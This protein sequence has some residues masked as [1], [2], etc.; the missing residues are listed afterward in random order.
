MDSRFKKLISNI[1]IFFVGTLG[2]R[3]IQ[4]IFVPFYTYWLSTEEYGIIDTIVVTNLL[5]GPLVGLSIHEALLRFLLGDK[6]D[7]KSYY[8]VSIVCWSVCAVLFLGG[9]FGFCKIDFLSQYWWLF[10]SHV[11]IN[12]LW[13]IQS[14]MLRGC[15]HNKLYAG[16]GML[17]TLL[18]ATGIVL[19]VR[20]YYLGVK[21][22]LMALIFANVIS[23]VVS[24]VSTKVWKYI[25]IKSVT[26]EHAKRMFRYC[27]PTMPNAIMWW[28]I[29][30]LDKYMILFF[31]GPEEEGIFAIA[32]KIPLLINVVYQVFL[33]AWQV[34]AVDEY[35]KEN[36][37]AFYQTVY[38][39]VMTGIFIFASII[40]VFIKPGVQLFFSLEYQEALNYIPILLL[41]TVF[42]CLAG[43]YGNFYTTFK[44]TKGALK[45]SSLCALANL[46]L[47]YCFVKVWGMFGVALA[48]AISYFLIYLYRV[49]DTKS[50]I[51]IK[52][53]IALVMKSTL[54][55]CIQIILIRY[56]DG[57]ICVVLNVV[58]CALM[59]VLHKSFL[60]EIIFK[61]KEFVK[62][63]NKR[64]N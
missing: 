33:M 11:V 27:L 47:N 59:L 3:I 29:N 61:V 31:Y 46:C 1:L 55:I 19:L 26:K 34:S 45:T 51:S 21:G 40:L 23:I 62:I 22:Y 57:S 43:Y 5:V 44:K 18:Q 56:L 50:I 12:S 60:G 15:E 63:K 35:Q 20:V 49:K 28:V 41:G 10:Y 38:N 6:K 64:V 52:S 58:A 54:V 53:E 25:S 4:F 39:V 16:I 37:E 7:V 17:N 14:A 9:Y 30:S 36:K 8:S 48:T 24:A 2:S 32:T 42:S 13:G